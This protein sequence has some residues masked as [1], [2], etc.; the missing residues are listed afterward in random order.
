MRNFAVVLMVAVLAFSKPA[1]AQQNP[2]PPTPPLFPCNPQENPGGQAPCLLLVGAGLVLSALI[3]AEGTKSK[4]T[5]PS[6]PPVS[7]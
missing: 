7:P 1:L 4:E 2:P 6:A 5:H 3:I